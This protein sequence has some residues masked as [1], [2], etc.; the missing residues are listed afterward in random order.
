MPDGRKVCRTGFYDAILI[1]FLLGFA[2]STDMKEKG[3]KA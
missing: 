1:A 2:D 3:V